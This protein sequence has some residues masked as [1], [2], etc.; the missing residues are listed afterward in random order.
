MQHCQLCSKP[1]KSTHCPASKASGLCRC[2]RSRAAHQ[3]P[4][5][6]LRRWGST[7]AT[8]GATAAPVLQPA[9]VTAGQT[10]QVTR[11]LPPGCLETLLLHLQCP[12]FWQTLRHSTPRDD[13][14]WASQAAGRDSSTQLSS[15]PGSVALA[16]AGSAALP[17]S[18]LPMQ[19]A[20]HACWPAAQACPSPREAACSRAWIGAAAMMLPLLCS[21][22]STTCRQACTVHLLCY[23]GR[24]GCLPQQCAGKPLAS[25]ILTSS[26]HAAGCMGQG[27]STAAMRCTVSQTEVL[28]TC[29]PQI[30]L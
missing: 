2:R 27:R 3:Q 15:C 7:R 10:V 8:A 18:M 28:V 9:R 19:A 17:L 20:H 21:C 12:A 29:Q 5:V 16:G 26:P 4:A 1:P 24:S 6:P 23:K 13:S 25:C 11:R 30:S 22:S 14:S